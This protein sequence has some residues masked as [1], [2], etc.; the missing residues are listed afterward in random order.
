V[1][2]ID[3]VLLLVWGTL[4][5]V[6]LVSVAQTM[7]ARPLVAGTVAGVLVG[8]VSTGVTLGLVFELYQF[9][10]LPVGATRYPEYGPATVAAMALVHWSG[11]GPTLGLGVA[12]G[13]LLGLL[14]GASVHWLRAANGHAVRAASAAL[15]AGD[16]R[17]LKRVHLHGLLRDAARACLVTA[18]GLAGANLAVA[19]GVE[20]LPTHVL[21]LATVAAIGAAVAS[22][23][24]GILRLVGRRRALTW[25][26]AGVL[27]GAV[28]AWIV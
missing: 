5:G 9:D 4:V 22:G 21:L 19:L 23:V 1:T 10:I 26:A 11:G 24:T 6:D 17:A 16:V 14:G 12:L 2:V 18:V 20:T 28:I 7:I 25:L 13:L 3:W 27:G 15:E 8:D